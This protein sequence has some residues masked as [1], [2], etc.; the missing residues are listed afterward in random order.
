F[1]VLTDPN[2]YIQPP[3]VAWKRLKNRSTSPRFLAVLREVAGWRERE[4]Q[5]RDMPRGRILRDEAVLEIAHHAP[6][7]AEEL[8]RTRGLSKKMAENQAG[9][10]ILEAVAKGKAVPDADCPAIE[11]KRD[12]PKGIG[13]V[14]DLLKVVLKLKSEQHHVAPKLLAT[15][16]QLEQI[17]A[18]GENADVPALQGWRREIFGNDAL[19]LT[20][21]EL[22][23]IANGHKLEMVEFVED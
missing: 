23:V 20:R 6:A 9:Q 1:S 16:G 14:T 18:F 22:G 13:P 17:A 7:T 5:E 21:G 19:A 4:A 3:D 11:S 8:S 10:G 12:L 2:T 15:S